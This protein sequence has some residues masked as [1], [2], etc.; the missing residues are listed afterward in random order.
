MKTINYKFMP[1]KSRSILL[2]LLCVLAFQ[3]G[4]ADSDTATATTTLPA[5]V[6]ED[7]KDSTSTIPPPR[8]RYRNKGKYQ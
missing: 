7:Q 8:L 1:K 6:V 5:M 2:A 3:D 4:Y